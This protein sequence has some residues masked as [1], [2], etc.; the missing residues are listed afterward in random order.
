[1]AIVRDHDLTAPAIDRDVHQRR[2]PKLLSKVDRVVREL[3]HD[4]E[5]PIGDGMAGLSDEFALTAKLAR[6]EVVN[7]SRDSV[8][9]GVER[10]AG[11]ITE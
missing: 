9:A 8:A 11:E 2:R 1:V 4:D 7:V 6:R 5:R 10:R 3:L